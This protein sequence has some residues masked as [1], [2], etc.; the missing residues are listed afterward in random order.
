MSDI[1][2]R[3]RT[4]FLDSGKSQ[5]EIGKM[6]GKTSQY[7][8]KL[9]NNDNSK[10]SESVLRDICRV[11]GISYLWLTEGIEPMK[12]TVDS[13]SLARIDDLMMGEN[14]FAKNLFKEF[15]KLDDSEWKALEK[16]IKNIAKEIE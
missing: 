15:A 9:L 14:E 3:I 2:L 1:L 8:W 4:V 13:D 10:P 12:G 6:I 5:T 7:V 16:L 11:F